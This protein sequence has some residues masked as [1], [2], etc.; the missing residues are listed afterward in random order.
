[1]LENTHFELFPEG[2]H[3]YG[4]LKGGKMVLTGWLRKAE[5]RRMKSENHLLMT[6]RAD[7]KPMGGLP[8]DLAEYS[9]EPEWMEEVE[10]LYVL[11]DSMLVLVLRRTR[12][13][14]EYERIGLAFVDP[15]CFNLGGARKESITII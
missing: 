12:N 1:M 7:G 4:R 2:Q 9:V 8:L 10:C 3:R 15:E 5:M 6:L 11:Q 13:S 14:K